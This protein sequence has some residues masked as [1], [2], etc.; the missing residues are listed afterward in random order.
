MI[1]GGKAIILFK[2][3]IMLLILV[4]AKCCFLFEVRSGFLNVIQMGFIFRVLKNIYEGMDR[5][6]MRIWP[7]GI[8]L[9]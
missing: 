6:R 9:W 3:S 2:I 7:R 5:I 4:M 1:L 8:L